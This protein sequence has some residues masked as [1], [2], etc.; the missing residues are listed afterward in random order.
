MERQYE[1]D[2]QYSSHDDLIKQVVKQDQLCGHDS[3]ETGQIS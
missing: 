2:T 3:A 1:K